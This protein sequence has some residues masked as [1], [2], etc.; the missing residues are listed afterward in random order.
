MTARQQVTSALF[1][2]LGEGR[3][4]RHGARAGQIRWTQPEARFEC[5][6][7]RTAE[8]PVVRP[9]EPIPAVVGRFI[10]YIRTTHQAVCTAATSEG[11][12]AA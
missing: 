12:R 2:D 9:G 11:V 8:T 4:I 10:A 6:I 5:L 1:V 3:E 7:C